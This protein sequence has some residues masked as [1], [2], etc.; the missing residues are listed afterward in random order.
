MVHIHYGVIFSCKEKNEIMN[1]TGKWRTRRGHIEY[2][3]TD[4]VRQ[5]LRILSQWSLL[6]PVPPM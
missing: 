5:L 4:A 2:G 6:V 1:F 3:D